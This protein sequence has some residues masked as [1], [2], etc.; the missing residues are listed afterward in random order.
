MAK[1]L[2]KGKILGRNFFIVLLLTT[3]QAYSTT[4]EK[5][6][7]EKWVE[8]NGKKVK[9]DCHP[10]NFTLAQYFSFFAN[11]LS[12]IQLENE[13]FNEE[14]VL[15]ELN[16]LKKIS[17]II[18]GK[19]SYFFCDQIQNMMSSIRK[20]NDEYP[21]DKLLSHLRAMGFFVLMLNG[22]P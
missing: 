13:N 3:S 17:V 5:R 7:R 12:E 21:A 11:L 18:E 20:I 15:R 19:Y 6:N 1:V 10:I 14:D 4:I 8:V 22:Q 16:T 2:K 9:K